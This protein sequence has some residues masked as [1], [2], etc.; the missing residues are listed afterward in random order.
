[1]IRPEAIDA[2]RQQLQATHRRELAKVADARGKVESEKA[3]VERSTN[4][5]WSRLQHVRA[6]PANTAHEPG[7]AALQLQQ[8][9]HSLQELQGARRGLATAQDLLQGTSAGA[10][11]SQHLCQLVERTANKLER[12]THFQAENRAFEEVS[13]FAGLLRQVRSGAAGRGEVMS[14]ADSRDAVQSVGYADRSVLG[15]SFTAMSAKPNVE[16]S[17][18]AVEAVRP[19][20]TVE[21]TRASEAPRAPSL[22]LTCSSASAGTFALRLSG[23]GGKPMDVVV[24][25][26]SGHAAEIMTQELSSVTA[27]LRALG[28]DVGSARVQR[29]IGVDTDAGSAG[30]KRKR[31]AEEAED[32]RV[33]S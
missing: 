25:C 32:E 17:A 27:K 5:F 4:Q 21:Q 26:A 18:P 31:S 22:S 23:G 16:P 3:R 15:Q 12:L 29:G 19:K 10:A 6:A 24:E 11:R 14:I 33:G 8:M 20:L 9:A 1:M 30:F 13:S 28:F 2:K 7:A